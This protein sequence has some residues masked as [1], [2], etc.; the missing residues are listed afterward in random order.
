MLVISMWM[1]GEYWK[2]KEHYRCRVFELTNGKEGSNLV[3][4]VPDTPPPPAPEGLFPTR[5]LLVEWLH[6]NSGEYFR[7]KDEVHLI[8]GLNKKVEEIKAKHQPRQ[9]ENQV[10]FDAIMSDINQQQGELNRPLIDRKKEIVKQRELLN[11]QKHAIN[12]QLSALSAEYQD[13]EVKAKAIN[14][15]LHDL[16]HEWITLNPRE[17]FI[18]PNENHV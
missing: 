7:K 14:R 4:V 9:L 13:I 11:I 5:P 8:E 1:A 2:E 3:K 16:K 10:E 12:Q 6:N 15:P 18:K 17:R